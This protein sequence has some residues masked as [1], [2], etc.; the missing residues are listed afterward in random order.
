MPYFK[1]VPCRI[2]VVAPAT[3]A[4]AI[5]GSCP[6]CGLTLEPVARP[7]EVLSFHSPNLFDASGPRAAEP[8]ADIT[9]GRAA[10]QAALDS[11][12]LLNEGGS[13]LPELLAQ[14]LA[15]DLPPGT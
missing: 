15:V 11:D 2:R 10:A 5:D 4:D 3:G 12:R 8:V 6:E 1:C 13:L 7:I 14:A 9:G